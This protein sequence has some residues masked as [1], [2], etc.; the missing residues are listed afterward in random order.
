MIV[1][2]MCRDK[3]RCKTEN[4]L[5]FLQTI[6]NVRLKMICSVVYIYIQNLLLGTFDSPIQICFSFHRNARLNLTL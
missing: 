4:Y 3:R 6:V 2:P 1:A 5:S